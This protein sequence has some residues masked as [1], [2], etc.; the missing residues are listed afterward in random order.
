MSILENFFGGKKPEATP[1]PPKPF[2]TTALPTKK[3]SDDP[4]KDP[5]M[6]R[7]FDKYGREMFIA[8]EQWRTNVLLGAIKTN[9]NIQKMSPQDSC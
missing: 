6:I 7:V 3:P 5:N 4:A 8:K 2:T 9:W 1:T